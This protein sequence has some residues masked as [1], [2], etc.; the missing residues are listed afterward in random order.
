[1]VSVIKFI[2]D[3]AVFHSDMGYNFERNSFNLDSYEKTIKV[4]TLF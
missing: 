3:H 2:K 1:M 4:F